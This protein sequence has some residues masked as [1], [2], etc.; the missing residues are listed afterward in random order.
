MLSA[1]A[2]NIFRSSEKLANVPSQALTNTVSGSPLP[3]YTASTSQYQLKNLVPSDGISLALSTVL[4]FFRLAFFRLVGE[5]TSASPVGN[6]SAS[7]LTQSLVGDETGASARVSPFPDHSRN[8]ES[9][10]TSCSSNVYVL[11][12]FNVG[13]SDMQD[14]ATAWQPYAPIFTIRAFSLRYEPT[15]ARC[16]RSISFGCKSLK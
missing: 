14:Q 2:R 12:V 9:L 15:S 13:V 5:L 11:E 4:H 8:S 16:N 1:S 7:A 10:A 3:S 6:I